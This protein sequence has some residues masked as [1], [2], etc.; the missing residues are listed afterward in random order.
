VAQRTREIGV[1]VALGATRGSILAMVL[2]QGLV[3][4]GV[5]IAIGL[6]AALAATRL[7]S[8]FLFGVPPTDLVTFF[9]ASAILVVVALV[10]SWA[11]ARRAAASDPMIA[12]RAE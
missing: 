1:R 7:L 3:L 12:L 10:A 9:G 8:D 6:A 5:G 4:A 2:R 11:P